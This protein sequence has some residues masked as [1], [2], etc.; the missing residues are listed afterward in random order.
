MISDSITIEND[1]EE[2][3][4]K[5]TL[6]TYTCSGNTSIRC[7]MLDV[8]RSMFIY[9]IFLCPAISLFA[10]EIGVDTDTNDLKTI[11]SEPVLSN[12]DKS[13]VKGLS[14]FGTSLF[15][16]KYSDSSE[17]LLAALAKNPHSSRIL[18]FLLKNFQSY[19]VPDSQLETFV[20]IAQANPQ[21][22][23]LNVAAL[24]LV[25]CFKPKES[26]SIN[27]KLKLAEKCIAENNPE[28][29]DKVEFSLFASIV[30][31]LSDIYLKEKKYERGNKLFGKLLKNKKLFQHNIFL[32]QAI[33]FYTL[34]AQKADD[35]R[36]LLWI[37][38]SH[39]SL[40]SARKRELLDILHA[41]TNRADEMEKILKHLAFLQKLELL[42]EAKA[43]L[44]EQLAKQPSKAV[45]QVALAEL[46][47]RQKKHLL[48]NAIWKKLAKTDPENKFFHLKLAQSAFSAQLYQLASE[49]F[50]K[51]LQSSEKKNASVVFMAILSELQLGKPDI[52]WVLLKM[53]P[54]KERFAEIRAHVASILGKNKEA[55]KILSDT[56]SKS[57]I[58]PD[59]KL[60]FFWLA[61]AGKT[62]RPEVQLKCLKTLKKNLDMKDAEAANSVGYTYAD[63]NK[64]LPEAK[65]LIS[66]A[67]SK[68]P[69]S[70][71][72][73]D[74]MA[75]VL[76]RMKQF[77]QSAIYI[78]K[79]ISKEGKYPNAILADHAG[80]IF[81]ALGNKKKALYYWN[82][83]LKIFSFDLDKDKTQ[84]K[85]KSING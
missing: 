28:K 21:A 72:Y 82:L 85:I 70:P 69:E 52:A 16:K 37:L 75:W 56:I 60:Y 62:E 57:P 27:L 24:S 23:A 71:E 34:A 65:K 36:R 47:S 59:R 35:S 8:R 67:L 48:A 11:Q 12:N 29:F 79:A 10:T 3:R 74:S 45:L 58:I 38:P 64:N 50:D 22:L 43:L 51:V 46:Y 7:S 41:R 49:N 84:K 32:H 44:L 1:V 4:S 19:D 55:F 9:F 2:T 81:Y 5:K 25:D 18:A 33:I 20:A 30:K 53:L 68:K 6:K 78:E 73:L 63:L 80:D 14:H 54:K 66:H 76:F 15:I 40:Y 31:S 17:R 13:D 39:A 83:A 42:D 61:L 77:K 26:S